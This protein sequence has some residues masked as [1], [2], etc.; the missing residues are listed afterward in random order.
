MCFL[1]EVNFIYLP[2]YF[3]KEFIYLAA[4]GLSV[5]TQDVCCVM[6]SLSLWHMDSSSCG[7]QA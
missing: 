6:W 7:E 4:L 2:F 1:F 3:K 5:G